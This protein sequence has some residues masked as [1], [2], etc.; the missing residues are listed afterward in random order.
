MKISLF[1]AGYSDL[2][3]TQCLIIVGCIKIWTGG[4]MMTEGLWIVV[5]KFQ[6]SI[7]TKVFHWNSVDTYSYL[8]KVIACMREIIC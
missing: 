1:G 3:K 4:E 7:K 2:S 6:Q 8:V 5:Y